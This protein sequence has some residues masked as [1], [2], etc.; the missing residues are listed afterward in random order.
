MTPGRPAHFAQ[1]WNQRRADS[2]AGSP[3]ESGSSMN[4]VSVAAMV[5]GPSVI[6][7]GGRSVTE[8]VR[9]WGVAVLGV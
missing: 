9:A 2:G 1:N 6:I 7:G 8:E 4:S 3:G 5:N